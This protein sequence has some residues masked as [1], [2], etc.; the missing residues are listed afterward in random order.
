MLVGSCISGIICKY[1]NW[2]QGVA[3]NTFNIE[4][5]WNQYVAMGIEL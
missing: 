3:R 1:E 2:T 5:I 4:E